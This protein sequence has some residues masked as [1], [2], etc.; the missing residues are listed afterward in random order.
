MYYLSGLQK[1]FL[2]A[3]YVSSGCRYCGIYDSLPIICERY[4]S[5]N[6]GKKDGALSHLFD[7]IIRVWENFLVN[8]S[9]MIDKHSDGYFYTN[10]P[11]TMWE[12]LN[13]HLK[14]ATETQCTVL[15]LMVANKI[16]HA[17]NSVVHKI[18]RYV[19]LIQT[20]NPLISDMPLE[21]FSAL[22]NDNAAH[23]EEIVQVIDKFDMDDVRDRINEMYD[24]VTMNLVEC[25]QTCLK[26]LVKILM[27]EV[28]GEFDK[29]MSE[30]WYE[31]DNGPV[32]VAISTISD[33]L[34]DFQ[35]FLMPF[36]LK[37]FKYYLL[38]NVVICY[39][40][41][42]LKERKSKVA[43]QNFTTVTNITSSSTANKAVANVSS[44]LSR[45]KNK[46]NAVYDKAKKALEDLDES[47][48]N[49]DNKEIKVIPELT[50]LET[51]N[52]ES[53]GRI[54]RDVNALNQFFTD[55]AGPEDTELFLSLIGEIQQLLVLPIEQI[56]K[57][58]LSRMT[59]LPSSAAAIH[60]VTMRCIKMRDDL[61]KDEVEEYIHLLKPALA[62]ANLLA[63]QYELDGISE[64]QLGLLYL[65]I[66]VT[67][68]I[69]KMTQG[70]DLSYGNKVSRVMRNLANI[71]LNSITAKLENLKFSSSKTK[72]F[73]NEDDDENS[74]VDDND[75][76]NNVDDD[77]DDDIDYKHFDIE[78]NK[79]ID[80]VMQNQLE[81]DE[82]SLLEAQEMEELLNRES[83][84]RRN[85]V[86]TIESH[87]DKKSPKGPWQKR[88]FKLST[89]QLIDPETN[90]MTYNYSLMWFKKRGGVMLKA[91]PIANIKSMLVVKSSRPLVYSI[92]RRMLILDFDK[93]PDEQ[94]LTV[95]QWKLL[96]N[97]QD[98]DESQHF[99]LS[100]NKEAI[101]NFYKQTIK[102]G[103]GL[104]NHDKV[105]DEDNF[106][107]DSQS[108][109]HFNI[110]MV[111]GKEFVL[112][113][114]K[115]DKLIKWINILATACGMAY[116]DNS[117]MWT[118]EGKIV[119][120]E[121]FEKKHNYRLS[122]KIYDDGDGIDFNKIREYDELQHKEEQKTHTPHITLKRGMIKS[123]ESAEKND[124]YK[125]S[126]VDNNAEGNQSNDHDDD[127]EQ[128]VPNETE[129]E[130]DDELPPPPLYGSPPQTINRSSSIGSGS[131]GKRLS[132]KDNTIY[133]STPPPMNACTNILSIFSGGKK[134]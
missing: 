48:N 123:S 50:Q 92:E 83:I 127:D 72:I 103:F 121:L 88:Y 111:D 15:H 37:K 128:F 56:I 8:P 124:Y 108:K 85:M 39:T 26:R 47:S 22:A 60:Y 46:M 43:Q 77:D 58:A 99:L 11:T 17:L 134:K 28:Q 116:D 40:K 44:F 14:L 102:T 16:V 130:D 78:T 106:D 13:I 113:A 42:L 131:S 94:V 59:S 76:N 21:F 57:H 32:P 62:Q 112:R 68:D 93:Y 63:Q 104:V 129:E 38:E 117:H 91:I 1:I 98:E 71:P 96:H 87:L 133:Q 100:A 10:C 54:A 49:N 51:I 52:I 125:D 18:H 115:V 97:E 64:S 105:G 67:V 89:K 29:L 2:P 84:D 30:E 107:T 23:I 31:D 6:D 7:H 12:S 75:V 120:A 70:S 126:E 69:E 122:T 19:D 132:S 34:K 20:D 118:K 82:K 110:N 73:F 36:W 24:S 5:G 27:L 95:V 90:K 61:D 33:Y 109:F 45:M 35:E 80:N 74:V 4:L 79:L 119:A 25:G 66:D 3:Q 65:D 53:L 9:E 55:H 86:L 41:S 101:S 81:I 114:T